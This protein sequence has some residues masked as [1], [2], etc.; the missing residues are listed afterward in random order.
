MGEGAGGLASGFHTP[1]LKFSITPVMVFHSYGGPLV[2]LKV[3]V[4]SVKIYIGNL[5]LGI[6]AS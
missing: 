3:K 4:I 2:P 5:C 6:F 1:V